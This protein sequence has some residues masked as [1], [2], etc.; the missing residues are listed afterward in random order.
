[1]SVLDA[2]IAD[3]SARYPGVEAA[4]LASGTTLITVP[5]VRLPNGWSKDRTTVRFLVPPAY[6]Y[7][8]LDCF[9]AD[10][11]LR[12]AGNRLPANSN[13]DN[14]IPE[15]GAKGLWFSWHLAQ[16][17]NPNWDSLSTWMNAVN[18][19]LRRLQ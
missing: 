16:S 2:Q 11:D 13:D 1:M 19:R 15:V 18:D 7:A 3:L 6:P 17:W 10:E 8:A 14:P 5:R 12:L 4:R 9:W